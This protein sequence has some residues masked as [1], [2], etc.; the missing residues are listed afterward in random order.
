MM[1][2]K[3]QVTR[4][5]WEAVAEWAAWRSDF[6]PPERG[7]QASPTDYPAWR[8]VLKRQIPP[9]V[10]RAVKEAWR[11]YTFSRAL[12][13]IV[14]LPPGDIPTREML[15][16]LRVGWDNE[17]WAGNLDYLEEVVRRAITTTGPILECGS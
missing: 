16:R 7:A 11:R 17:G 15:A 10:K 12:Q 6:E 8:Q 1:R 3:E 5:F 9:G 4:I 2:S 14:G 13:Q